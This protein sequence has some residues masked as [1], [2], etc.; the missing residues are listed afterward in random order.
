MSSKS[1]VLVVG[2]GLAGLS[3]AIHLQNAGRS[4]TVIESSDRAGGRVT[5]DHIDG[6][7]CDRGFQLINSKYPALIELDGVKA[8]FWYADSGILYC[9][10]DCNRAIL[11]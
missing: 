11:V 10:P 9:K 8:G 6:Y 4:V 3:A 7:I 2:A 1:D 5:S